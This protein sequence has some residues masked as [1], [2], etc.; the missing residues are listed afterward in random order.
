LISCG[1]PIFALGAPF[2]TLIFAIVIVTEYLASDGEVY[3]IS[4]IYGADAKIPEGAMLIVEEIL[5][6]T[7]KYLSLCKEA[8]AAVNS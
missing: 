5:E 8:S 2:C 6:G 3:D 4:L 1:I 7:E